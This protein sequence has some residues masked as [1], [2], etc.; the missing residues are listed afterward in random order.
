MDGL[1]VGFIPD[2]ARR[3]PNWL[4][5]R[6]ALGGWKFTGGQQFAGKAVR[7]YGLRA[8]SHFHC[9]GARDSKP[10]GNGVFHGRLVRIRGERGCELHNAV[11]VAAIGKNHSREEDRGHLAPHAK[12]VHPGHRAVGGVRRASEQPAGPLRQQRDAGVRLGHLISQDSLS[13]K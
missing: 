9:G 4:E 6:G 1:A 7:Y 8:P 3:V 10:V 11:L 12:R 13:L 5:A 2:W